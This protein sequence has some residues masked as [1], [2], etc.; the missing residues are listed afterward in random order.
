MY[1]DGIAS[2]QGA[3]ESALVSQV[4][5]TGIVAAAG[6]HGERLDDPDQVEAA[7]ARCLA[8]H[9]GGRSALLHVALLP[10]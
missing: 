3:F 10:H 2:R 7:I 8:A 6:G 5:F 9:D 4:D 1:P